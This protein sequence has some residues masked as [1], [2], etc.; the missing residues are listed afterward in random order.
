MSTHSFEVGT[1]EAGFYKRRLV[2]NGVWIAAKVWF[3]TAD[4]DEVGDLLD[5]EGLRCEVD[6]V[7]C[8][9]YHEWPYIGGYPIEEREYKYLR[10]LRNWADDNSSVDA[11]ANPRKPIDLMNSKPIF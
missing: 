2:Q 5:D 3:H 6:G 1:P 7:R 4:R 10:A 11:Y 9:P 8:N